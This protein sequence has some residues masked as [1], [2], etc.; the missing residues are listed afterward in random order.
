VSE[1][2][3]SHVAW[4]GRYLTVAIE[5]WPDVGE[6]FNWA[7]EWFDAIARGNDRTA[8]WIVEEDGSEQRFSFAQMADRSNRV[9]T[10]LR[11]Q[12]H[13]ADMKLLAGLSAAGEE[14]SRRGREDNYRK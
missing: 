9:A 4:S 5:T 12:G 2:A 14:R 11:E 10:W 13:A 6:Q 3:A 1:P 8:L 7:I